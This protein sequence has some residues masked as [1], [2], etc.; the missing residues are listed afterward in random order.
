[1]IWQYT[2]YLIP[3]VA[4]G[5][6]LIIL[7]ITGLRNRTSPCARPYSL[8]MFA[9]AVWAFCTALELSSADLATQMLAIQIEYLAMVAVPIGWI[10]FALEYTGHEEW[11]TRKNIALLCIIPAVTM[12]MVVTNSLHH[13]FYSTVSE[14]VIGNLSFHVVTYGPAFW[15][16]SIYSYTL[17]VATLLLI[18]QRFLFTSPV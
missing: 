12:M 18:F 15:L 6:I 2:P 17:I 14:V 8:L 7:A 16:H 4:C 5:L 10:L 11:I 3:N 9:A 1:M 13:L